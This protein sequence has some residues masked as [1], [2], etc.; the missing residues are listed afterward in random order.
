MWSL[1]IDRVAHCLFRN[2]TFRLG[3]IARNLDSCSRS[4][5]L[6]SRTSVELKA[7]SIEQG[8]PDELDGLSDEDE[9]GPKLNL[10]HDEPVTTRTRNQPIH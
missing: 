10:R 4:F 5:C 6:G 3:V 2:A 9:A 8:S 7:P 1:Q